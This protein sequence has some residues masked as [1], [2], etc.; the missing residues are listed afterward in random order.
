MK[1]TGP[2]SRGRAVRR[3]KRLFA[4]LVM[5]LFSLVFFMPLYWM[6]TTALKDPTVIF[7]N[8]P[9]MIPLDPQWKNFAEVFQRMPVFTEVVNTLIV[10]ILPVIGELFSAP[11]VAY[12]LTKIPWKG[13][14]YIF[15]VILSTMMIPWQVTQIP[16]FSTWSR[17]GLVNTFV[18]LVLPAFFGGAY[19]VYLMRQFIKGLPDSVVEAARIDGA[20]EFQILYRL[21]YPMCRPVL[22]TISV[23][24]FMSS[25]NDLNGPLLYLQD[26]SKYTLSI[27]LQM[28]AAG[29]RNEWA[30]LMA[31]SSVVTIPLIVLFF[32]A[33]K[34][35][36]SGIAVTSGLK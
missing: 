7:L 29:S 33:Q 2:N 6:V 17:L 8:P 1:A 15:P 3:A 19:Y 25:W 35:I 27:G 28:F 13:S 10:S 14:K 4:Y 20:G 11:M 16:M 9:Q 26:S 36:L 32:V 34:Q 22:T 21:V 31:A 24:I 30:L 12:S 18:P 5:I 23:L